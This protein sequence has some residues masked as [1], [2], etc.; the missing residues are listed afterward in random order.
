[1][2]GKSLVAEEAMYVSVMVVKVDSGECLGK[3]RD[4]K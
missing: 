1:V 4:K 2:I 3:L